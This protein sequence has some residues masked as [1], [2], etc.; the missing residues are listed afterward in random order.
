MKTNSNSLRENEI[1]LLQKKVGTFLYEGKWRKCAFDFFAN[2]SE[3]RIKA[4]ETFSKL[5]DKYLA[6]TNNF[7][8]AYLHISEY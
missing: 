2:I 7:M 3:S 5:W 8:L 6:P 4:M 1:R